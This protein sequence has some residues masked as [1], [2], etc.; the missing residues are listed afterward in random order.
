[1]I[2]Q[3]TIDFSGRLS[4]GRILNSK[5]TMDAT[6]AGPTQYL[7][8][9]FSYAVAKIGEFSGEYRGKPAVFGIVVACWEASMRRVIPNTVDTAQKTRG[10]VDFTMG[11]FSRYFATVL[12][13]F[14]AVPLI[15][16]IV[17]FQK[18]YFSLGPTVK[19]RSSVHIESFAHFTTFSSIYQYSRYR[20]CR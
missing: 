2:F 9:V 14:A 5:I 12:H 8:T 17:M 15:C 16:E 13:L 19:F 20:L 10:E 7:P 4:G 6:T 1:M 11:K 18:L 3:E